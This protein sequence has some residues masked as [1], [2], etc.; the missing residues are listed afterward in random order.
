MSKVSSEGAAFCPFLILF[1]AGVAV[2]SG[3]C[4]CGRHVDHVVNSDATRSFGVGALLFLGIAVV[5]SPV[6]LIGDIVAA[7][8]GKDKLY[9][10]FDFFVSGVD[11]GVVRPYSPWAAPSLVPEAI[12]PV[13]L[14]TCRSPADGNAPAP[15]FL[16][17]AVAPVAIALLG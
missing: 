6:V 2:L 15:L 16:L 3:A 5:L 9:A 11:K 10:L 12:G 4:H 14:G 8:D 1:A 13:P 17:L 7:D